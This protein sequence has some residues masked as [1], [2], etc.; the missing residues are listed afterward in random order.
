MGQEIS[1]LPAQTAD[2][3]RSK[4]VIIDYFDEAVRQPAYL[5]AM[6]AYIQ[7]NG[8]VYGQIWRPISGTPEYELVYQILLDVNT[9]ND[10]SDLL[11]DVT[12]R[13]LLQEGDKIGLHWPGDAV[14]A[15]DVPASDCD[16]AS[17]TTYEQLY[18]TGQDHVL[19]IG[20]V[21]QMTGQESCRR[22][23][24]SAHV[25]SPGKRPTDRQTAG[26]QFR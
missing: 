3:E 6:R 8:T 22:H 15:Y 12:E 7:T 4:I 9:V 1:Y 24:F 14:V 11:L 5:V 25:V 20:D 26:F 19:D 2:A 21:I 10:G 16:P 17:Q 13:P 23:H 18:T